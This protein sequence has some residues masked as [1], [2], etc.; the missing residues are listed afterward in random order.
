MG[1][2]LFESIVPDAFP[3]DAF[4]SLDIPAIAFPPVT[5]STP[6]DPNSLH[7]P[8]TSQYVNHGM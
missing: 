1:Q 6:T 8:P 3:A 7:E 2:W 4:P 5:A